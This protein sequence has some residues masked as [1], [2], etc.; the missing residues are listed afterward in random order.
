MNVTE[1]DGKEFKK[2]RS[3]T[4]AFANVTP[5]TEICFFDDADEK[6]D[7]NR[8]F[9]RTTG[10]FYVRRM[11]QNP[12]S[13]KASDAPKIVI[14]S[15]YPLGENDN[16]TRRRQF[17]IEVGSFYKDAAEIYGE[18]PADIHGG[19]M[20]AEEGGGWNDVDWSEFHRFVFECLALYLQKGLPTRDDTSDNFKRSQLVASF[21][22]SGCQGDAEALMTSIWSISTNLLTAVKKSSPTLSI[23]MSN[24]HSPTCLPNGRTSASIANCVM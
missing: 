10:D 5:A 6:F 19:K 9:S 23:A 18:T 17:V 15:N 20:I 13:I 8:L 16:S 24:R 3:D 21:I 12:F 2:G 14:T 11:R 4:F 1:L 22:N 7:T